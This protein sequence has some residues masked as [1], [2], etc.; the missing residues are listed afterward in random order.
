MSDAPYRPPVWAS[1]EGDDPRQNATL[2][3]ELVAIDSSISNKADLSNATQTVQMQ[4]LVL[5]DNINGQ[6][7]SIYSSDGALVFRGSDGNPSADTVGL[8]DL[9]RLASPVLTGNPTAPTQSVGNNSTRLAT[10]AFVAAG[11]VPLSGGTL[12]GPLMLSTST[13]G[14]AAGAIYRNANTLRYRDST[15]TERTLLNATDNLANL[16]NT[17]TARSNLGLGNVTNARALPLNPMLMQT[18]RKL[19]E[20]G[21]GTATNLKIFSW[22][23]SMNGPG[24]GT[25]FSYFSTEVKSA[26]GNTGTGMQP[27]FTISGA[28]ANGDASTFTRW[29]SGQPLSLTGAGGTIRWDRSGGRAYCDTLKVYWIREPGAGTFTIQTS[30]DGTNW[31]NETGFVSVSAANASFALG[32]ATITKPIGFYM[33]RVL[34]VSGTV[35][36]PAPRMYTTTVSGVECISISAGGISLTTASI[37]PS[38]VWGA[39]LE[40]VAPDLAMFE[41]KESASSLA[42]DLPAWWSVI[43]ARTPNTDWIFFGSTPLQ[44]GDAEQIAQNAI[45]RTHC[46]TNSQYYFDAYELFDKS[47]TVANSYGFMADGTHRSSSGSSY[48]A[49]ELLRSTGL[50]ETPF[51][52]SN[53]GVTTARQIISADRLELAFPGPIVVGQGSLASLRVRSGTANQSAELRL[54]HTLFITAATGAGYSFNPSGAGNSGQPFADLSGVVKIGTNIHLSRASDGVMAIRAGTTPGTG[55]LGAVYANLWGN[56]SGTAGLPS[57]TFQNFQ[58]RGFYPITGGIGVS[59]SSSMVASFIPGGFT[60][61]SNPPASATATGTT[62][63]VTWDANF[64]YVC[65]ATN[66]WRR[67]AIATW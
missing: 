16:G 24:E 44:T 25:V 17:A 43:Q 11:F 13:T 6:D 9:A 12:T 15:N 47:W 39:Y 22:S 37:A 4:Q 21:T 38:A 48:L 51:G 58:N 29:P 52:M 60:I 20:M 3:A 10:T 8:I 30:T 33:V 46:D 35:Y 59:V 61:V 14:A 65:V 67:T 1:I 54:N 5:T 66:T 64:I 53:V 32:I 27:T 45:I 18:W 42:T 41:M 56:E 57:I 7:A 50:F 55:T 19:H 34:G 63:Q 40:D 49:K 26:Y 62:G 28:A 23:D 2:D 36:F 31:T